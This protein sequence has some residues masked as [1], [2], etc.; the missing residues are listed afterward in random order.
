RSRAAAG[1]IRLDRLQILLGAHTDGQLV[2]LGDDDRDAVLEEAELLEALDRLERR[3]R[4]PVERFERCAAVGVEPDVL[5]ADGAATI[6]VIGQ[7]V[8]GEVERAS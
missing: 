2:G 8:P 1:Q 4:K 5:E 3:R 7:G 6:T